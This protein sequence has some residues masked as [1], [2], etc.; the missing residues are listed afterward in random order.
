MDQTFAYSENIADRRVNLYRGKRKEWILDKSKNDKGCL[1]VNVKVNWKVDG[2]FEYLYHGS[3]HPDDKY[4]N[5][6]ECE[7]Q[8]VWN[9]IINCCDS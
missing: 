6:G 4:Q 7:N 2:T 9:M 3:F 5:R 8:C 1:K